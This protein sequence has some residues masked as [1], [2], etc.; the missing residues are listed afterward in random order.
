MI[1]MRNAKY[2]FGPKRVPKCNLGTRRKSKAVAPVVDASG[3]TAFS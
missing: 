2:N 1:I 3:A